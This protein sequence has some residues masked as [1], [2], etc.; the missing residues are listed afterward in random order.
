MQ[1]QDLEYIFSVNSDSRFISFC[2]HEWGYTDAYTLPDIREKHIELKHL[3]FYK[4]IKNQSFLD[5]FKFHCKT[6]YIDE[7]KRELDVITSDIIKH[8]HKYQK[9]IKFKDIVFSNIQK[10]KITPFS[11]PYI[12]F[13]VGQMSEVQDYLNKKSDPKKQIEETKIELIKPKKTYFTPHSDYFENLDFEELRKNL[14]EIKLIKDTHKTSA[15]INLFDADRKSEI[16][17]TG[18]KNELEYFI[19]QLKANHIIDMNEN[20]WAVANNNLFFN[21]KKNEFFTNL[22]NVYEKN[23]PKKA[24]KITSAI[25]NAM[26]KD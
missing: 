5:E 17:W 20:L 11:K 8:N 14:V 10:W 24:E 25:R 3:E 15:L 26:N 12:L 22:D 9:L 21:N 6:F 7:I 16:T 13:L 2:L 1:K 19:M 4:K 23:I 18:N